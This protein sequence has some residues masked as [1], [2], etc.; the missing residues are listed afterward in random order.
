M[1]VLKFTLLELLIVIAIIGLLVTLL[2][3]SLSKARQEALLAVCK[4]NI[5][6]LDVASEM[7]TLESDG[8]LPFSNWKHLEG[9][10]WDGAGWLYDYKYGRNQERFVETGVLWNF[11]DS[12]SVFRCPA[13]DAD[14]RWHAWRMT[15]CNM[16]G[17]VNGFGTA[18]NSGFPAYT[19][20][21]FSSDGIYMFCQSSTANWNDGANYANEIGDRSKPLAER[22][23][24][25]HQLR[26]N[27]LF[28]S[29][30][31]KTAS[32][33]KWESMQ[34]SRPGQFYCNPGSLSGDNHQ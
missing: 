3:P 25:R 23:P 21:E 22:L 27:V 30:A 26:T 5:H 20:A 12:R 28:F 2:L 11:L 13:D 14:S 32:G 8:R 18:F 31:I 17:A 29:G 10:G 33:A 24:E 15:S 6:Q 1:K 16:N 19:K 4:N 7:Y 9:N 34:S